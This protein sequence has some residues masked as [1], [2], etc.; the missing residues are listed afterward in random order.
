MGQGQQD[1][2]VVPRSVGNAFWEGVCQFVSK[3][4][5]IP[6]KMKLFQTEKFY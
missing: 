3:F 6:E 2:A 1:V 4:N 5:S